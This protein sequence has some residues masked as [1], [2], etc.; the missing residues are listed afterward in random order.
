MVTGFLNDSDALNP[1]LNMAC[2][3]VITS[4]AGNS[5]HMVPFSM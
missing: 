2:P 1:V 3:Q 5:T 4:Q